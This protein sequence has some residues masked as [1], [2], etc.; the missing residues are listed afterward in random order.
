MTNIRPG[1]PI[2]YETGRFWREVCSCGWIGHQWHGHRAA[3]RRNEPWEQWR[4]H[5]EV[6]Y[7]WYGDLEATTEPP[8]LENWD[9]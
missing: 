1:R 2:E 4:E 5:R 7:G 9:D 8:P 3:V 6:R